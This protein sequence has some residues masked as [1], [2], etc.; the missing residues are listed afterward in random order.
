MANIVCMINIKRIKWVY[1]HFG[2]AM[3]IK[4]AAIDLVALMAFAGYCL[5]LPFQFLWL[6][7]K[8]IRDGKL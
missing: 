3:A 7:Y 4:S 8:R 2:L 5:T 6:L 1:E